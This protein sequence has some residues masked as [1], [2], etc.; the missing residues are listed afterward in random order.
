MNR[1]RGGTGGWE[2]FNLCPLRRDNL[3]YCYPKKQKE[4]VSPEWEPF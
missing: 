4:G 2:I 3:S 1:E